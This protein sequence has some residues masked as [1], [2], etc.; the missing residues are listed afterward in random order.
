LGCSHTVELS[1]YRRHNCGVGRFRGEL[2]DDGL[3]KFVASG[4]R[5]GQRCSVYEVALALGEA[6]RRVDIR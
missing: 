2:G 3:N 5:N 6:E 4:W 1:V